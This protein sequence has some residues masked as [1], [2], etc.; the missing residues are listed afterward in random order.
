MKEQTGITIVRIPIDVVDPIG[1]EATATPN[2]SMD[3]IAFFQQQL[4]QI[5]TILPCDTGDECFFGH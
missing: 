5:R 4:C 2:D 1:V 3:F